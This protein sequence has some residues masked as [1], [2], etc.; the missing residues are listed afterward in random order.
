[1]GSPAVSPDS[2]N[3]GKRIAIGVAWWL[4]VAY[5]FQF[6]AVM[7]GFSPA[8][9]PLAALAVAVLVAGLSRR[10]VGRPKDLRRLY[11][12]RRDAVGIGVDAPE[13]LGR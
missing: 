9:G 7:Y 13:P 4:A 5:A 2:P 6:G 11:R 1:M 8:V 12:P 10:P 3:M